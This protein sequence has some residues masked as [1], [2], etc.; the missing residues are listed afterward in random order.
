MNNKAVNPLSCSNF[1]RVTEKHVKPQ[2]V[3]FVAQC[4]MYLLRGLNL[5][6]F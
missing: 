2:G 5:K 3:R 6:K 1:I 4:L